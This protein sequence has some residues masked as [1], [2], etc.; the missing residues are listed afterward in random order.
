MKK[1]VALIAALAFVPLPARALP[2]AN[3]L[4][5]LKGPDIQPVTAPD[6]VLTVFDRESFTCT[7]QSRTRA[8]DVPAGAWDRI[9]LE[10]MYTPVG[11]PWDRLF[12]VAI[13]GVE[14][15]RG[16]SARTTM[17]LRKDVTEYATLLPAG[18][19]ADVTLSMG[20]YVGSLQGTV[21]IE[22]YG[23]EPT[24]ALVRAPAAA[25]QPVFYLEGLPRLVGLDIV[26]EASRPVTFPATAPE[27]AI[28]E[29]TMSSHGRDEVWFQNGPLR[30]FHLYIDDVEIANIYP[31]PYRYAFYGFGNENANTACVGPGTSATGDAVHPVMWWTAQRAA[32][33]AGV[34][35][36]PGEILAHRFTVDPSL[37]PLLTGA[38]TARLYVEG[39]WPYWPI[40]VAIVTP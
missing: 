10:Y 32:D 5:D 12:H 29:M 7:E 38:R 30:G 14:V 1:I 9:I 2:G 27:S 40:S 11:D 25:M 34:H 16:T 24:G 6:H 3:G 20:T 13:G 4:P 22:W 19:T 8:I 28:V 18:G 37:L 36:G 35:T 31:H 26:R 21:K 17:T 15:L 23:D 39:G 33:A